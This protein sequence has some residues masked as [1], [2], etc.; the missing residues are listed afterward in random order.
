VLKWGE[1]PSKPSAG[2]GQ[3][4]AQNIFT[5]SGVLFGG[6]SPI[7][8]QADCPTDASHSSQL[9]R[10]F[11]RAQL[12]VLPADSKAQLR[13]ATLHA[14]QSAQLSFPDAGAIVREV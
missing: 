8:A 1:Q 11:A 4:I 5:Q 14:A 7:T 2:A 9:L 12:F 6:T 3:W 10:Q 13:A